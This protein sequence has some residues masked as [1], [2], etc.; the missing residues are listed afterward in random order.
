MNRDDKYNSYRLTVNELA[1]RQIN[2]NHAQ[3]HPDNDSK[4]FEP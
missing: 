3:R 1:W 2:I 4:Q